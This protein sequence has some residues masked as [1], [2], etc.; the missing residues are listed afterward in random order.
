M[1]GSPLEEGSTGGGERRLD[2]GCLKMKS[3]GFAG[4]L[5]WDIRGVKADMIRFCCE[6]LERWSWLLL[7]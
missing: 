3:I 2:Y 4:G 7:K 6:Q 1:I 5:V